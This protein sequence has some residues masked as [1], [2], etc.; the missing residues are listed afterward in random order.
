M[1]RAVPIA[2]ALILAAGLAAAQAPEPARVSAVLTCDGM[3]SPLPVVFI[4][5]DPPTAM[6]DWRGLPLTL[7]G[8]ATGSGSGMRY[9]ARLDAGLLAITAQRDQAILQAPGAA[10]AQCQVGN[11]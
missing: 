4:A 1:I 7:E 9:T 6:L 10:P 11:R 5:G 3:P 2:A 8:A